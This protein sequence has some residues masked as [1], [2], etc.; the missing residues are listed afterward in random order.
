M[1]SLTLQFVSPAGLQACPGQEQCHVAVSLREDGCPHNLESA[2]PGHTDF[3]NIKTTLTLSHRHGHTQPYDLAKFTPVPWP[4][5][6]TTAGSQISTW[7]GQPYRNSLGLPGLAWSCQHSAFP[8]L[9]FPPLMVIHH[10]SDEHF[11]F[12]I[13]SQP[14][15]AFMFCQISSWNLMRLANACFFFPVTHILQIMLLALLDS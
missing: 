8:S 9:E 3:F 5:G 14:L 10:D 4:L 6:M 15:P 2:W 13:E 1:N 7:R 11:V 12:R